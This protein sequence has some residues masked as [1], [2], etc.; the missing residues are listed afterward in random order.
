MIQ[1]WAF[2]HREHHVKALEVIFFFKKKFCN[3]HLDTSQH[4]YKFFEK[5]GFNINYGEGLYM[6][7]VSKK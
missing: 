3:I 2:I 7:E 4:T 6:I 5:F 1:N